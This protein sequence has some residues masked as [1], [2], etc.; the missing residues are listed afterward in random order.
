MIAYTVKQR[1]FH[2]IIDGVIEGVA[3]R[4]RTSGAQGERRIARTLAEFVSQEAR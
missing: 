1:S 2:E 3:E 4:G